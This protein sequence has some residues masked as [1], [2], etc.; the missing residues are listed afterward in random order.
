MSRE[1][2]TE[3]IRATFLA[4]IREQIRLWATTDVPV[5]DK[6][7]GMAFSILA[8]L[9]G[10]ACLPRFIVAPC[11]SE[12]DKAFNIEDD[13]NYFPVNNDASLLAKGNIAGSLHED[14]HRVR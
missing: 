11:S 7:E 13:S 3:E 5:E 12:D 14:L 6:L 9:D 4:H 8:L 1:Y 10:C 2:T